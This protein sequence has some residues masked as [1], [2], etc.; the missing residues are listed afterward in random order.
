MRTCPALQLGKSTTNNNG[1]V[2]GDGKQQGDDV[3]ILIEP[4]PREKLV[5]TCNKKYFT[6]GGQQKKSSSKKNKVLYKSSS[7]PSILLAS[8]TDEGAIDTTELLCDEEFDVSEL[9]E[10][11]VA[12]LD[13]TRIP[14]LERSAFKD[15]YDPFC[16]SESIEA[17]LGKNLRSGAV[18]LEPKASPDLTAKD[19][20]VSSSG[21]VE[22]DRSLGTNL[23]K[24]EPHRDSKS[25]DEKSSGYSEGIPCPN[26]S[27]NNFENFN[28]ITRFVPLTSR[29]DIGY[30]SDASSRLS[31]LEFMNN[32]YHPS[33]VPHQQQPPKPNH[34]YATINGHNAANYFSEDE[35][36]VHTINHRPSMPPS[37]TQAIV[38]IERMSEKSEHTDIDS[39]KSFD[40]LL[41]MERQL[42]VRLISD[43]DADSDLTTRSLMT[44]R[45]RHS[46][47]RNYFSDTGY[48][49]DVPT[50]TWKDKYSNREKTLRCNQLLE[51]FKTSRKNIINGN[52]G[53]KTSP[54]SG[55]GGPVVGN[56]GEDSRP[57][58][59]TSRPYSLVDNVIPEEE[60]V[61]RKL[62]TSS[63]YNEWLV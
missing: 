62:S 18:T 43:S 51:E 55:L 22:S 14:Q 53:E 27:S 4:N 26:V 38:D 56:G 19:P 7:S 40:H 36:I 16:R 42:G 54:N 5:C 17:S 37:Y 12:E 20:E 57:L 8:E 49:S 52:G 48:Q 58:S 25:S 44:S 9:E 33:A 1:A 28:P 6:L 3:F 60:V 50:S 30:Y 29:S 32:K 23:L 11:A 61:K 10:D 41:E 15:S 39:E 24:R 46:I 2:T 59:P 45:Y 21:T 35:A 13:S 47:P 63:N 34:K 31:P